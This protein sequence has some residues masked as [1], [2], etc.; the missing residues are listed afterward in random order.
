MSRDCLDLR[1]GDEAAHLDSEF[2]S[3][4]E[5]HLL[6]AVTEHAD[7]LGCDGLFDV[8]ALDGDAQLTGVGEA[9]THS[10]VGDLAQVC[11]GGNDHRVLATEFGGEADQSTAGLLGEE[12]TGRGGTGEHEVVGVLDQG[13]A[14]D[15]ARPGNHG[16]EVARQTRLVEQF[17]AGERAVRRLAV[18][19]EDNGVTGEQRGDG[20]GHGQRHRV[21]P[22]RDDADYAL[23]LVADDGLRQTREHAGDATRTQQLRSHT[24]VV[25]RRHRDVEDFFLS[26]GTRLSG[27]GLSH[28]HEGVAVLEDE[29]AVAVE[30]GSAVEDG[31]LGPFLLGDAGTGDGRKC[32][33]GGATGG[34]VASSLPVNT[35]VMDF[36][37]RSAT[38][39][40][41]IRSA[42]R[43]KV[44]AD[45]AGIS[46]PLLVSSSWSYTQLTPPSVVPITVPNQTESTNTASFGRFAINN[47]M[48]AAIA[49][50]APATKKA[51]SYEPI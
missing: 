8:D 7:E 25:P 11:A 47:D 31:A 51:A 16:E 3:G 50:S 19:L 42:S 15:G 5:V 36:V 32:V 48:T 30:D 10:G 13:G 34:M 1:L 20:V 33:V 49:Q 9:R 21:V 27:L 29:I 35:S 24:C 46:A 44:A 43:E 14:D 23:G 28:V 18:R 12:L 2:V 39:S 41:A 26:C 38:L 40:M 22:R 4:G 45:G 17:D 6:D 37:G